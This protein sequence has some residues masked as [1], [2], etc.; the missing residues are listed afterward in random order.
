M[1]C[2]IPVHCQSRNRR[3]QLMPDHNPSLAAASPTE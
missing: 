2:Q 1:S 3:P